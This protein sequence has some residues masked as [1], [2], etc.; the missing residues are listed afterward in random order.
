MG[1]RATAS[2][3]GATCRNP[4]R[5]HRMAAWLVVLCCCLA[6]H[7]GRALAQERL[8]DTL[9]RAGVTQVEFLDPADG[10]RPLNYMMVYPAA[11]TANAT[12]FKIFLSA[13]LQ[14]SK[15]A[16]VAASGLKHPLVMFS[17][18]AGGNG[19]GYAWFAEYLAARGYFVALVYHYKANTFDS[20]AVYVRNRLWQRPRDISLQITHILQNPVFGPHIDPDRI[21]VAG[22]SQGGFTA[23][24]LGGAEVDPELFLAFQRKW[25]SNDSVPQYLRAQM[26]LDAGPARNVRDARVKAAFAMAPGDIQGFGMDAAGLRRMAIPAYVVVGAGDTTTP[27]EDN[28]A[29]AAKHIPQARLDVLPGP[30][31]HEIFTNICDQLGRDNYPEACIDAPGIDRAKLHQAIGNAAVRFFDTH[32][33]VRR[34]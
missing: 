8:P 10:G 29:F 21:G 18:G 30:V 2:A 24:W 17:H 34:R 4:G 12:P 32:L 9:Y 23:L 3:C 5:N 13:D 1:D 7:A 15:D 11:D 26:H 28:A 27:P 14:L 19:S 25:K 6:S 31:G 33:N 20:S 22:H 16:P